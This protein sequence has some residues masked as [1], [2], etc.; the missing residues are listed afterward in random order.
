MIVNAGKPVFT[1][2]ELDLI[3]AALRNREAS[4]RMILNSEGRKASELTASAHARVFA[5]HHA[6]QRHIKEK[7]R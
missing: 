2:D 5:L 1:V 7:G 4:L 6:L 3:E